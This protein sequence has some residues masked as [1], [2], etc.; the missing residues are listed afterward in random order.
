[1]I[2][3]I[4]QTADRE[5]K[6]SEYKLAQSGD[7]TCNGLDSAEVILIFEMSIVRLICELFV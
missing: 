7:A 5:L 6:D 4:R 3:F 1:M 2:D